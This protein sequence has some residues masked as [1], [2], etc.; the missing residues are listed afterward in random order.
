M[1]IDIYVL[2]A[3]NV[4]KTDH[5]IPVMSRDELSVIAM[6]GIMSMSTLEFF[7]PVI[8]FQ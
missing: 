6:Q 7:H 4:A 1:V 3:A 5:V 2:K 8:S